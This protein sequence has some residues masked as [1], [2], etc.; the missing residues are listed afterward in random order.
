MRPAQA[1]AH[2]FIMA[3]PD[4]YDTLVGEKGVA[5]SGGQKQRVAIARALVRKPRV[6]LLDEATSA[7]VSACAPAR[8]DL[9]ADPWRGKRPPHRTERRPCPAMAFHPRPRAGCRQRGGRAGGHRAHGRGPHRPCRRPPALDRDVGRPHRGGRSG[10]GDR[11]RDARG[12]A[13]LRGLLCAPLRSAAFGWP[14]G[15]SRDFG[16]GNQ[17][18]LARWERSCWTGPGTGPGVRWTG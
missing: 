10:I 15:R 8:L 4:G 11:G 16:T 2:A 3:L 13:T 7:L 17:A 9:L 6:L 12:A 5:L 18:D 1:N 14:T